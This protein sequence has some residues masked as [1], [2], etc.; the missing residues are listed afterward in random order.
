[1]KRT[2]EKCCHY[3]SN[4]IKINSE[5]FARFKCSSLVFYICPSSAGNVNCGS[6][7]YVRNTHP[8]TCFGLAFNRNS[9]CEYYLFE[10]CGMATRRRDVDAVVDWFSRRRR[11]RRDGILS[12]TR[13]ASLAAPDGMRETILSKSRRQSGSISSTYRNS[14]RN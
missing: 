11:R 3:P 14:A 12:V 4:V 5:F 6:R 7:T 9:L 2:Q 1:M 8:P 10:D 13:P